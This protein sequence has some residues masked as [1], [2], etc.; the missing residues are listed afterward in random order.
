MHKYLFDFK[1]FKK[2]L[3]VYHCTL[4]KYLNKCALI[5]SKKKV[6]TEV[7]PRIFKGWVPTYIPTIN[8]SEFYFLYTLEKLSPCSL[9]KISLIFLLLMPQ[10]WCL[11][12]HLTFF[13]LIT[14]KTGHL[15]GSYH[16]LYCFLS[17]ML[18]FCRTFATQLWPLMGSGGHWCSLGWGELRVQLMEQWGR[19]IHQTPWE[20]LLILLGKSSRS[21]WEVSLF[22]FNK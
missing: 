21:S 11:R 1:L 14:S 13:Y 9:W 18:Q 10:G 20:L 7:K 6:K 19:T 22:I 16:F 12:V 4:K 3:I 2:Y 5:I 8:K 17:S 15:R